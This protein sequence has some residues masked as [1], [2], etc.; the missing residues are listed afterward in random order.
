MHRVCIMILKGKLLLALLLA[1]G[2]VA[3]ASERRTQGLS[4]LVAALLF[5]SDLAT[6]LSTCRT[7]GR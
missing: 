5:I 1:S 4:V 3:K 6:T 2:I 7:S